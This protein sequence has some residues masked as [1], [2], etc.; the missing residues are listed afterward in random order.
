MKKILI[1]MLVGLSLVTIA[2]SNN[3][4]ATANN[5]TVKVEQLAKKK[6]TKKSKINKCVKAIENNLDTYFG[7]YAEYTVEH[8]KE[9]SVNFINVCI[10]WK[11]IAEELA[12]CSITNDFTEWDN[13]V[14]SM[15]YMN[16]TMQ[17]YIDSQNVNAIVV[18]YV[19]NDAANKDD[20]K[21]LLET[22][23][24]VATYNAKDD[25]TQD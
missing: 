15:E 20:H 3:T 6:T 12:Y 5:D 19:M 4:K 17:D 13:L 8:K 2:P 18:C 11:G 9:G 22:A 25:L 23:F 16:G 7:E 10:T 21:F 24:G 14:S 1:S